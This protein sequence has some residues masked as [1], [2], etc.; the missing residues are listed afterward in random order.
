MPS[1]TVIR[2]DDLEH[3]GKV[4]RKIVRHIGLNLLRTREAAS[5]LY[6]TGSFRSVYVKSDAGGW[7]DVY[8]Q[9]MA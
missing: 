7:L 2:N 4:G 8:P 6:A 9:P 1:V 5:D 3:P